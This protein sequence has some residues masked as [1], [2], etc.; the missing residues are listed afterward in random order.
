TKSAFLS[1]SYAEGPCSCDELDYYSFSAMQRLFRSVTIVGCPESQ[2]TIEVLNVF[3]GGSLQ[4]DPAYW[5]P[6]MV[7]D[8]KSLCMAE[9]EQLSSSSQVQ[10]PSAYDQ[11]RKAL[12]VLAYMP[13]PEIE[14]FLADQGFVPPTFDKDDPRSI[15]KLDAFKINM[16]GKQMVFEDLTQRFPAMNNTFSK[17]EMQQKMIYA[18]MA[19]TSFDDRQRYYRFPAC[20]QRAQLQ[21]SRI[22]TKIFTHS[23]KIS[24]NE[25][26]GPFLSLQAV[27]VAQGPLDITGHIH[28]GASA[29][30]IVLQLRIQADLLALDH[31]K[32]IGILTDITT[33]NTA[34]DM[35]NLER[36]WLNQLECTG[37]PSLTRT[38]WNLEILGGAAIQPN[39]ESHAYADCVR[40]VLLAESTLIAEIHHI[41]PE[42]PLFR[43]LIDAYLMC[44]SAGACLTPICFAHLTQGQSRNQASGNYRSAP[45]QAPS[46]YENVPYYGRRDNYRKRGHKQPKDDQRAQNRER[47][48]EQ[49]P[50]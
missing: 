46:I 24:A 38:R 9:K 2:Q 27:P 35:V 45:A 41:I 48:V 12:L 34:I 44:L 7:T 28:D 31:H 36:K 40:A 6:T 19:N 10:G 18:Q 26:K 42:Q 14:T 22:R 8:R 25:P 39:E 3:F 21:V 47:R 32:E 1:Q 43:Y 23:R 4:H 11:D 15:E 17:T 49:N 16:I 37:L 33:I 29:G 13:K 20:R 5:H 30:D 50:Q